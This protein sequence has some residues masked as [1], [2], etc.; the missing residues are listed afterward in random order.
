MTS[1]CYVNPVLHVEGEQNG[2]RDVYFSGYFT[3]V[4]TQSGAVVR[5]HDINGNE[6]T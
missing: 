3:P 6:L 1:V 4:E 2:E 5:A